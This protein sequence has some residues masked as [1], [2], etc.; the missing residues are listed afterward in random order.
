[1]SFTKP[2]RL[3]PLAL[4]WGFALLGSAI[5]SAR[6]A[7]AAVAVIVN[8]CDEE[9]VVITESVWGSPQSCRVIPNRTAALFLPQAV[10]ARV[11]VGTAAALVTLRPW[12]IHTIRRNHGALQVETASPSRAQPPLWLAPAVLAQRPRQAIIPV[13][14]YVDDAQPAQP[15]VWEPRLR[16]QLAA[17]S[18]VLAATCGVRLQVTSAGTWQSPPDEATPRDTREANFRAKTA[19]DSAWV[20]VGFS[21]RL[22]VPFAA[23]MQHAPRDPLASHILVPDIHPGLTPQEQWWL[24]LHEFAHWLG[25]FDLTEGESV[26]NPAVKPGDYAAKTAAPPWDAANLLILNLTAD[27]LRYRGVRTPDAFSSGTRDYLMSLY[28]RAGAPGRRNDDAFR[29]IKFFLRP[30]LPDERFVAIFEDGTTVGG[31]EVSGWGPGGGSPQLGGKA[32]FDPANPALGVRQRQ[33]GA[34]SSPGPGIEFFGEDRLSGRVVGIRPAGMVGERRVPTCLEVLPRTGLGSPHSAT[35]P[36]VFV[37]AARLRRIVLHPLDVAYQPGTVFADDGR[38]ISF[39]ALQWNAEGIR[40]LTD[41]GVL[42]F[43]LQSLAEIHM[44]RADIWDVLPEQWAALTPSGDDVLIRLELVDGTA[45]T[46]SRGFFTALGQGDRPD[47]WFHVIQ[48]VWS[49][50]PLWIPYRSIRAWRFFSPQRVPLTLLPGEEY[51]ERPVLG[52]FWGPGID[53]NLAGGPLAVGDRLFGWGLSLTAPARIAFPLPPAPAA[54]QSWVGLD[55]IAG[56]GGSARAGAAVARVTL[57]GITPS[58]TTSSGTTSSVTTPSATTPAAT[59]PT[60]TA[61]SGINPAGVTPSSTAS[62]PTAERRLFQSELLIGSRAAVATGRLELDGTA[63]SRL[64][65]FTEDAEAER[66]PAADAWNVR[67]CVDWGQPLLLLDPP[68][69]KRELRQRWASVIPA[70]YGWQVAEDGGDPSWTLETYADGEDPRDP[71]FGWVT[72]LSDQALV[73]A[74]RRPIPTDAAELRVWARAT[75]PSPP[76]GIRLEAN[77]EVLAEA[78]LPGRGRRES[79]PPITAALTPLRGR[80]VNL[81]I[82]ARSPTAGARVEWLAITI[83]TERG[84]EAAAEGAE[85]N[86]P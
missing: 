22:Q 83:T 38:R 42:A 54:F 45:V 68:W 19:S 58:G 30:A 71:R 2:P 76:V 29:L 60:V 55:R 52:G 18:E 49:P 48:P 6:T 9:A 59:A 33:D 51:E 73:L 27:E 61:P 34:E 24:L 86:R 75:A 36:G 11:T 70:W 78:Q 46:T 81:R 82:T 56:D 67:D 44:P 85:S 25:A 31:E 7:G 63:G 65:L 5:F 64:V 69:I 21:S 53:R 4:A 47:Q 3:S 72:V 28:R 43:D 12:E 15:S 41:Q 57:S 84:A 40:V 79:P 39:R 80:T 74:R 20:I 16:S 50:Q 10:S 77:D 8:A 62:A 26:M 13:A 17:V 37:I 66:P 35:G 23:A 32:F 14:V 1:M